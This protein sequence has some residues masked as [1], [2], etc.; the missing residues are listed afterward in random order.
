MWYDIL[1]NFLINL[2][3][4]VALK[5]VTTYVNNTSSKNDDKVLE[6]AKIGVKYLA[7]RTTNTVT[8]KISNELN[9]TKIKNTQRRR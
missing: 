2:L 3:I 6:V 8:N 1:K 9:Q 5:T 7:S 4:P